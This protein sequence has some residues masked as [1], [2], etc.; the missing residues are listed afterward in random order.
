MGLGYKWIALSQEEMKVKEEKKVETNVTCRLDVLSCEK[1]VLDLPLFVCY[2]YM[3]DVQPC[4]QS[5]QQHNLID[6]HFL[7]IL[8]ETV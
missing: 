8:H 1:G 4:A 7:W 6:F 2:Y 3:A 5:T